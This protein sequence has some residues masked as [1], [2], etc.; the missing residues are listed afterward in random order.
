[1]LFTSPM[2][3]QNGS[4]RIGI[5]FF[6]DSHGLHHHQCPCTII[7][8]SLCSINRIQM[9]RKND[10]FIWFFCPFNF[11]NGI[12]GRHHT[13]IIR[14]SHQFYFWLMTI[15]SKSIKHSIILKFQIYCGN[16]F[17]FSTKNFISSKTFRPIRSYN[18][19]CTSIFQCH[20]DRFT[21]IT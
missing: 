16:G 10:I 7:C 4:F 5:H 3:N 21:I 15:F 14:F 6:K 12:K 20:D 9:C 1:M 13:Q 19:C 11:P 2:S 18:S 8:S 17:R